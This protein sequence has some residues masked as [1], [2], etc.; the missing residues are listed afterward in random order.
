VLGASMVVE[1]GEQLF[2]LLKALRQPGAV[3]CVENGLF[4]VDPLC[5][6]HANIVLSP[7]W[8]RSLP[9][10]PAAPDLCVPLRELDRRTGEREVL[11]PYS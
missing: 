8:G 10:V 4:D 6:A 3:V 9:E 2:V 11:M 1:V 5:L 7:A